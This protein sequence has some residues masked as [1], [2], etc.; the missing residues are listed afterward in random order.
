MCATKQIIQPTGKSIFFLLSLNTLAARHRHCDTHI[1]SA[2]ALL[3]N[4]LIGKTMKWHTRAA[5]NC[6][7]W[8]CYMVFFVV[9]CSHIM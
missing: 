4:R 1:E 9:G 2:R 6:M 3:N 5:E 8:I 7:K